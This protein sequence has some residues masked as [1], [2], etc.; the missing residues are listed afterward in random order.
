MIWARGPL[1]N[2]GLGA[3]LAIL[4]SL[5]PN[6]L[7]FIAF[8][9]AMAAVNA[10]TWS[11]DIGILSPSPPRLITSGRRV[12]PGTS[13]AISLLGTIAALLGALLIG[14]LALAQMGTTPQIGERCLRLASLAALGRLAG[15][16]FDSLLGATVQGIYY[17]E[18]WGKET[19]SPLH[20]CGRKARQLRGWRWL[21]NDV[22]NFLCSVA[23]SL[24]AAVGW[25]LS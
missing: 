5:R 17:C 7:L 16:L 22:V 20:R 1:A 15:S 21:D 2:G 23:G 12:P 19:E 18:A 8:V 3:I 13:G 9:G 4:Y 24:V 25:A 10:D 11:T 6:P 14:L